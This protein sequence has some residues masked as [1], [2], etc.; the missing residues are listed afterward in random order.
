MNEGVFVEVQQVFSSYI[1][2]ANS[3]P[4]KRT[5]RTTPLLRLFFFYKTPA[6]EMI[7]QS[8]YDSSAEYGAM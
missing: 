6:S 7:W 1:I 3:A 4:Y 8:F 2:Y 5:P